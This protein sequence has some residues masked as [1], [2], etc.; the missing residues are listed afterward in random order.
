MENGT[1]IALDK[2]KKTGQ[3]QVKLTD[4]ICDDRRSH[5]REEQDG[6]TREGLS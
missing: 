1:V 6:K 5:E 4:S 3:L 2:I